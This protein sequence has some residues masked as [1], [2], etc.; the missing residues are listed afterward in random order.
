M[1]TSTFHAGGRTLPISLKGQLNHLPLEFFQVHHFSPATDF[2]FDFFRKPSNP[3]H[4]RPDQGLS[5]RSKQVVAKGCVLLLSKPG[6][7][8]D[9]DKYPGI[10]SFLTTLG[11]D[12]FSGRAYPN[13][14]S[15]FINTRGS[16]SSTQVNKANVRLTTMTGK[17]IKT[18]Y[19]L[20]ADFCQSRDTYIVVVST[21]RIKVDDELLCK[22]YGKSSKIPCGKSEYIRIE[23]NCYR[24]YEQAL[25][26]SPP[27]SRIC[28]RCFETLPSSFET[29][30]QER[31]F[32]KAHHLICIPHMNRFI[33][34]QQF[35]LTLA[36]L[37]I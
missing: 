16:I 36:Q 5:M 35:A 2:H 7:P 33:P 12:V 11:F 4:P 9:S 21:M 32:L 18:K 14:Y 37:E 10:I 19:P 24:A 20:L 26:N 25:F 17:S 1:E 22:D 6:I 27:Q 29:F 31:D 8:L 13:C 28:Y 15:M 30:T 23:K 34:P 3:G